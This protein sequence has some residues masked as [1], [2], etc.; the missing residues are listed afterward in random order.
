MWCSLGSSGNNYVCMCGIC[1]Y[2]V[3]VLNRG[4][5]YEPLHIPGQVHGKTGQTLQICPVITEP[6]IWCC[7]L[8]FLLQ[9]TGCLGLKWWLEHQRT[10]W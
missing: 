9:L 4:R 5:Q 7:L 8:H 6:W 10:G 1:K 2:Y 3:Y